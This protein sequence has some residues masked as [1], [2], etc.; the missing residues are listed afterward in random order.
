M[1][2]KKIGRSGGGAFSGQTTVMYSLIWGGLERE[3]DRPAYCRANGKIWGENAYEEA[4][5]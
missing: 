2:R 3:K 1:G 4:G 5:V